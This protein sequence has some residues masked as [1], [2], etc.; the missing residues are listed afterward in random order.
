M[1]S[2]LD[3]ATELLSK[4]G[5]PA[6]VEFGT[7]SK[8][9]PRRSKEEG[10]YVAID[11]DIV[12]VRQ[13]GATDSVIFE[14]DRWLRDNEASVSAKRLSPDHARQYA[15]MYAR[16]KAGQEMPV[17]GTPIKGWAVISPSQQETIIR[18]GVRT[19]EDL[20]TMNAEAAGKIG[21]G[22]MMI[23]NRAQA[24]VAQAQDKGPLTM[25]M[26]ELKSTNELLRLQMTNWLACNRRRNRAP[27]QRG[28]SMS[29]PQSRRM[30]SSTRLSRR[31]DPRGGRSPKWPSCKLSSTSAGA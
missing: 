18:A 2:A 13:I 9:L 10:R 26:A 5:R 16:W 7:I 23:K 6:Y 11:V 24:W 21:M 3:V 29:P 28:K 12:T 27:S 30:R 22:A 14:V 20:A 19:V 31:A 17:E 15:S 4:D 8:E 25:E 1:S